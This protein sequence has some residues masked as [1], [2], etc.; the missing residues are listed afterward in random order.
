[1]VATVLKL[2]Y[3]ILGNTFAGRPWSLVGFILG[4]IWGLGAVGLAIAAIVGLALFEGLDTARTA[5]VIAGAALLLGWVLGPILVAG[6]D[7]IISADQLAQFPFSRADVMRLL[8]A[9]GL[10]G[11]PGIAASIIGIASIGLWLRWPLAALTAIPCVAIAVLTCV[12]ASRLVN[13]ATQNLGSARGLTEIVGTISLVAILCIGPI[14]AGGATLLSGLASDPYAAAQRVADILG[15]TPLGAAWSVP[16]Q[17]ASGHPL[18]ALAQFAIAALTLAA[19]WWAWRRALDLAAI[20]PARARTRNVGAGKLGLFGRV[21][22]GP[23]GATWARSLRSWIRD[24]RYS[25]QLLLVLVIPAIFA[26]TGGLDGFMF[27]FAPIVVALIFSTVAYTEVSYD[28][29]AFASVIS[30][31][32][33]GRDDRLGRLLGLACVAIPLLALACLVPPLVSGEWSYAAVTTGVAWAIALA[34]FG[35]SMVSSALIISPVPAPGD[36]PFKSVPGQTFLNGLLVFVVLAATLVLALPA[37]VLGIV[38][39]VTS[40]SAL[41][42]TTLG[43]GVVWGIVVVIVGVLIGGRVFDR[44]APDLLQ[45]IKAL[46]NN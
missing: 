36:N 10:A 25:R 2:R 14:V 43:V 5:V 41:A 46:P 15:W 38:A 11:I 37:I 18:I 6:T 13:A 7:S 1:M 23:L 12:V 34:G 28:G 8:T 29:T 42:W 39:V 44:T 9:I 3:R 40:D 4:S 16:A 17:V 45:R 21:G 22:T 31:G 19:L 32:I 26:F 24:P 27:Q 33:R 30:S 20:S 35:V